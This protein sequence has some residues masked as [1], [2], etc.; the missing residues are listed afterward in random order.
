MK[1]EAFFIQES[2]KSYK[3]FMDDLKKSVENNGFSI[4]SVID[5]QKKFNSIGKESKPIDIVQ[6]CNPHMSHHAISVD[7]RMVCL[8]PKDINVYQDE[9]GSIKV[10]FMRTDVERL[11]Q[12][13]PGQNI[14]ELSEKV[15]KTLENIILQAI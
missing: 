2:R 9:D 4:I 15:S 3:T 12:I 5:M 7:K 1:T 10:L 11:D 6:L 14:K 13:F 8:M